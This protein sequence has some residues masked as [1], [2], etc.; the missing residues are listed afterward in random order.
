MSVFRE[1]VQ[2]EVTV[3]IGILYDLSVEC[4]LLHQRG[5]LK[6]SYLISP[7]KTG[8]ISWHHHWFSGKRCLWNEWKNLILRTCHYQ[9][10][11]SI[12]ALRKNWSY[13][14]G[15]MLQP[16]VNQKHFPDQICVGSDKSLLTSTEFLD[17]FFRCHFTGKPVCSPT[18]LHLSL[19]NFVTDCK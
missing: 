3:V 6:R 18:L 1:I 7:R 4:D 9:D 8:E 5:C 11:Y 14:E 16:A 12:I 13:H 15:N 2:E 10:L 19:N 17:S